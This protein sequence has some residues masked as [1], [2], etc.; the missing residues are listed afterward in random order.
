[1][2]KS[3]RRIGLTAL[4]VLL[5]TSASVLA[6]TTPP[7]SS[8]QNTNAS[9]D[10]N[11]SIGEIIVTAQKRSE[12]AKDVPLSIT[13]VTGDMMTKLG[14]TSTADLEKV[15]P[16]FT[17]AKSSYGAPIFTLRGIG[18]YDEAVAIAPAVSVYVDQ[19][20]LPYSRMAEAVSLDVQRVEVLKGPQGTLFGQNSTGGAINY[21]ANKP[22]DTLNFGG[23]LSYG[24]FNSTEVEGYVSGPISDTVKARFALR[25]EE[26][27]PWQQSVTSSR[28][29][30]RRDYL[31]GRTLVDYEPTDDLKFELNVN[32][33]RDR[34]ETQAP[35]YL[36][37]SA[38]TPTPQDGGPGYTGSAA[39]PNLD[40]E[41]R[42]YPV[43]GGDRAADWDPNFSLQRDDW[44]YQVALHGDLA[45]GDRLNLTSISAYQD[46]HV[47]SPSNADG[48]RFLDLY[49]DV[50]AGILSF[51]QELRMA[52]TA[53][54]NDAFKY[55]G[56]INYQRDR[57][58][59]GQTLTFDGTN[60]GIG[61]FRYAGSGPINRSNQSIDS[62]A[63]FGSLSYTIDQAVTLD[64]SGRFTKTIR[65]YTGCLSDKGDGVLATAFGFLSNLLNGSPTVPNPGD[66]GY[67]APGHCVTFNPVDNRPFGGPLHS[68]LR[69][70]NFS[71]RFGPSWKIT[72]DSM[73]Y[74][75]ITRGFKAGS[76]GTV[77]I[78]NP[79]QLTPLKQEELTA[80]EVGF[81]TSLLDHRI[82]MTGAAFYYDYTNKQLLGYLYTGAIFGNLPAEVSV[83]QSRVMGS[84]LNVTLRPTH[85]LTLSGAA[86]YLDSSIT[87]NF[88]TTSPDALYSTSAG[89]LINV[90]GS[91]FPYTPK[92]S[93]Q[94]DAQYTFPVL[95]S[96]DGFVGA[97]VNF[98]TAT[99]AV[100]GVPTNPAFRSYTTASDY[101]IPAYALLDLRA[102]V[103]SNDGTYRVQLWARNVTNTYY[104]I[105]VVKIQDTVAR[106]T[107]M[108]TTVGVTLSGRF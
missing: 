50:K 13:A 18:F 22:T 24:S 12:R 51:N 16:G 82:D 101:Q 104:W 61:P 11:A 38:I 47:D 35:Q 57:S 100:L 102:G 68:A 77:P 86:T 5:S 4:S 69:E 14:V 56:G 25:S 73:V 43:K 8:E 34:S 75:N 63:I 85:Q 94:G 3:I 95:D 99:Y 9:P 44:F 21:V 48:T 67:I 76:F 81:K 74:A 59:D 106:V 97:N 28:E 103:E 105:H 2:Q 87:S 60:S 32:G 83:P 40:A 91:S 98:R 71:W 42:A 17:Y 26:S 64:A 39:Q 107:G 29:N 72:P 96:W 19:A 41:L 1:M 31:A 108:P 7:T 79:A 78:L 54:Q 6:Q 23:D 33:W 89:G 66:P 84:E 36:K 52:G 62:K 88:F 53:G 46:L 45:L 70:D 10:S 90:K 15:V 55:M 58:H 20:P 49:T 65:D 30:G 80:Y 93:L 92:W 37:Y 27:G